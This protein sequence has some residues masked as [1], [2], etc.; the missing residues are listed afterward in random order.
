MS[1]RFAFALALAA[2]AVPGLWVLGPAALYFSPPHAE[3]VGRAARVL[4]WV[5]CAELVAAVAALAFK[6]FS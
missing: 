6:A 3:G 4:A 1:P 2:A 5:A